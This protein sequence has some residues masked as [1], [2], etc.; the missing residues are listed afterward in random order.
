MKKIF[1]FCALLF[2]V[3]QN[4]NAK[5]WRVNNNL[6]INADFTDLPAAVTAAAAG[7]TL[8]V[9]A[10]ATSY[11]G[12]TLTKKLIIIGTGYYFTDAVPNPKTQANI[13]VANIGAVTFDPG[14]AGSVVEGCTTSSIFLNESN[15]TL[16]R[17]NVTDAYVYIAQEDN[18]VCNNDT[19]RQNVIYGLRAGTPTGKATNLLVY[20]NIFI[21]SAMQASNVN[22][23]SGYF[24]NNDFMYGGALS[25]ENFTFQNNI[26]VQASFGSYLSSNSFFNNIADNTGIPT[27]NGNQLSVNLDKVFVGYSSGT[28]FSSDGRYKLKAGSPAIGAGK[29]NGV[30]VDCGA[31]GDSAPYVLS[32]IPSIP[33]I[34]VLTVPTSVPSGATSMNI[35]ISSTTVH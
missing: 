28:G 35:T 25:C 33:S 1:T 29:L 34:Y 16:Q 23:I 11:S 10:S 22:N 31:F 13:N 17:D 9:E 14:C 18:S 15:V 24:I 12:P 20:N 27:G 4:A 32:G 5:I 8:M 19:I 6:G 2:I 7:D 30:T 3:S 26:F 21:G